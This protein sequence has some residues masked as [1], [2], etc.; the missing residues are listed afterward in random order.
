[1]R[2]VVWSNGAV[3]GGLG[4]FGGKDVIEIEEDEVM[5]VGAASVCCGE[6]VS[7]MD[8]LGLR[9][10]HAALEENGVK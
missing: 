2:A 5:L 6:I 10:I 4:W 1:M 7:V 3:G 8:R 9:L